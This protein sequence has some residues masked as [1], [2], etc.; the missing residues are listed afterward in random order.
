MTWESS[1]PGTRVLQTLCSAPSSPLPIHLTRYKVLQISLPYSLKPP[2]LSN[3]PLISFTPS[4]YCS[5]LGLLQSHPRFPPL[6]PPFYP[7]ATL[8]LGA[9]SI[10]PIHDFHYIPTLPTGLCWLPI[11]DDKGPNFRVGVWSFKRSFVGWTL[12]ASPISSGN[13]LATAMRKAAPSCDHS[14]FHKCPFLGWNT[15][16]PI[17]PLS[18]IPTHSV[19]LS[20]RPRPRM[21]EKALSS[22]QSATSPFSVILW[23]SLQCL[24]VVTTIVTIYRMS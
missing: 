2:F 3:S 11:T 17:L 23:P 19:R 14:R 22:P 4:S 20:S 9:T 15:L 1:D 21:R 8:L 18:L 5:S 10:F 12:M 13:L 7:S 6:N 16:A 24:P